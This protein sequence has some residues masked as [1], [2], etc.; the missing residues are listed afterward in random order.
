MQQN[1]L[2]IKG[3]SHQLPPAVCA[4]GE[5]SRIINLRCR[6]NVWEPVGD[7]RLIYTPA[8]PSRKVIFLHCNE[9]YKHYISYLTE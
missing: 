5:C 4:D 6:D 2:Q 8:D 1:R 7:P 9:T 3:M